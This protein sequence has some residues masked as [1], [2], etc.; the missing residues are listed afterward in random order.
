MQVLL[1]VAESGLHI[2]GPLPFIAASPDGLV[3]EFGE[4]GVLE[5]KCPFS[6]TSALLTDSEV[7]LYYIDQ[8]TLRPKPYTL[9]LHS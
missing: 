9:D 4:H 3:S 7:P 2:L 8:V 1:S 5:I 6:E